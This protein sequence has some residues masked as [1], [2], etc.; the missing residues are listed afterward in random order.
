MNFIKTFAK[1]GLRNMSNNTAF[2]AVAKGRETG[3]F[4]TWAE[5]EKQVKNFS[6]PVYR[7]FKVKS[8]AEEFLR[9]N[10]SCTS[11]KAP[12]NEVHCAEL[13]KLGA[14]EMVSFQIQISR[15]VFSNLKLF[16]LYFKKTDPPRK[17]EKYVDYWPDDDDLLGSDD[18]EY[19]VNSGSFT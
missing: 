18:D 15:V 14:K 10:S 8:E 17:G 1:A 3:I 2:Y 6:K 19:L 5:C 9:N 16:H 7:K 4:K 12:K 13:Y 11:N